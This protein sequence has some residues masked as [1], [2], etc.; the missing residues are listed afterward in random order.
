M[1][2]E[3]EWEGTQKTKLLVFLKITTVSIWKCLKNIFNNI[4]F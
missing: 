1:T 3:S 2:E 4:Y